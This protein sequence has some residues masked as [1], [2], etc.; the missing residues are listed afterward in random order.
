MHCPI[1]DAG[2]KVLCK[3]CFRS[4]TVPG[5]A[6][7]DSLELEQPVGECR[8]VR[9]DFQ[10]EALKEA[11][12]PSPSL[13]T[14]AAPPAQ[15]KDPD[16]ALTNIA[17]GIFRLKNWPCQE[18]PGYKAFRAKVK[19]H[20]TQLE[21]TSVDDYRVYASHGLLML[22]SP[23]IE[24]PPLPG[25]PLLEVL[26][27]INQRSISSV[28]FLTDQGVSM[29]HAMI[30]L[31]SDE[32]YLTS[33][34]LIQILR[35]M[36]H[37]RRH[38]LSLIRQTVEERRVDPLAVANAFVNPGALNTVS[39]QTLE[40]ACDMAGF[41]GFHAFTFGGQVALSQDSVSP[42]KCHVRI[43]A[44]PGFLR[45]YVVLGHPGQG[46]WAFMPAAVRGFLRNNTAP[47]TQQILERLNEMNKTSELVRY[48]MANKQVVATA[49]CF[50][51]D[52]PISVEQFKR[53]ADAL[54]E[55]APSAS[56]SS[57]TLAKAG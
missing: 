47:K 22:E 44:C 56:A 57:A 10:I 17:I 18:E 38:A 45:G 15:P 33:A 1:S 35:Q 4:N 34:M 36:N 54:L 51:C 2:Q 11:P 26:N 43:A 41:A 39:C 53:F 32:N 28:F 40:Q 13:L 24:L 31:T 12:P 8:S 7:S 50:P 9:D 19:F 21:V 55:N 6:T 25:V 46:K 49:A 3:V 37:D 48:V 5:V 14:P 20:S 29:R 23:V 52:K 27:E 30:P 16:K 42:E